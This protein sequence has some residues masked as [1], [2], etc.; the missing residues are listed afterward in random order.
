MIGAI[1]TDL[2]AADISAMGALGD[3]PFAVNVPNT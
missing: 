1:N 2:L 3:F